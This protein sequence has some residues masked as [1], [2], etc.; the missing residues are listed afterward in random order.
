M[1]SHTSIIFLL[2][3]LSFGSPIYAGAQS[4]RTPE[5][6]EAFRNVFWGLSIRDAETGEELADHNAHTLM[7][8]AS[9]MKLVSTGTTLSKLGSSHRIK[10]QLLSSGKIV[11]GTLT[12]DLIIRGEG[13][14]SIGS[15]YFWDEDPERFFS[16]ALSDLKRLGINRIEGR[17]LAFS[18]REDFQSISP[19]WTVY[20]LGNH[21]AAGCYA[22]NLFDNAYTVTLSD[23]GKKI[24]V[25]PNIDGL[26][27]RADYGFSSSRSS[28]SLY[29]SPFTDAEG[30]YLITGVYPSKAANRTVKGAMPDP[31]AFFAQHLRDRLTKGGIV[32]TGSY[33]KTETLPS[34]S[35]DTLMVYES[36]TLFGLAKITNTY[37][38][39]LFAEG[40]LKLLGRSQTPLPG[41]NLTQTALMELYAYWEDRGLDT[42]ELEMLDGSGLSPENRVTPAFLTSMLGKIYREDPSHTFMQTLP[43]AGKDGTLTIFLKNTPLE[44]KARLK[45]GTIRN[46]VTYAGY[47][48]YGS[49]V[50]TVAIMVN[51]Y[52]GTASS[53]RKTMEKVLTREFS[54]GI[55]ESQ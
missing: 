2:G 8:P 14:F 13:D 25:K 40:F 3:L 5:E 35:L 53:V 18:G 28:D 55:S 29:I 37:S 1:K 51:N 43:R 9:T 54:S 32:V 47:V 41:H 22:L 34:E 4:V 6:P 39:N 24:S 10:T 48:T 21:Y 15:R 42:K 23:H 27:F 20:D 46:V 7:T 33:G 19:R 50:Y 26:S 52:Y 12:G 49:K 17:I 36:P 11:E 44:G 31:P 38:H 30:R 16:R 45:S